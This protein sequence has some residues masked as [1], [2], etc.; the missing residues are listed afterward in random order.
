M[1]VHSVPSGDNSCSTAMLRNPVCPQTVELDSTL[2]VDA[3]HCL[4]HCYTFRL[5]ILI[6]LYL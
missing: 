6:H 3:C 4:G 2:S 1:G 5:L